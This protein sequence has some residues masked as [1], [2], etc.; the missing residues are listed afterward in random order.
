MRVLVL[1]IVS[2]LLAAPAGLAE[3][4]QAQAADTIV[5]TVVTRNTGR[6]VTGATV[7]VEGKDL[8]AA[9]NAFGR[10]E[11]PGVPSEPV[12]L[13][14]SAPGYLDLRLVNVAERADQPLIIDLDPTPNFLETVQ[15]TATKQP[16]SIG[17]VPAQTTIVDRQTIERR[18]DQ[19]L[20]QA[21][22]HV[23][24]AVITTQLGIFESVLLRGMP[25][26][27]NEFTNTLLLIDGVPQTN[28]G[29]DARVVAL[30]IN[31]AGSIE[32][33]RGPNSALYGRTAIGGSINVLTAE[34]T[35]QPE[36]TVDFTGG[37]YGSA[38]GVLSA[39]GPINQWGGYYVSV[40]N[41]R[42]GGY[43][44][45]KVDQNFTMGNT[46][47]FG[48]L[49]FVPDGRSFGS[50]SVNRVI[51]D[52]STPTNEP[53]ID[54]R[55]LHEVDPRFERFTSFNLPGPN[56]HQEE[57]RV[58]FNYNRQLT[59]WARIVET[60]GYRAVQLKFDEDGDFIGEPYSLENHT[61]TMYPFSQQADEDVYYQEAR[62][63]LTANAGMMRHAVTFGGSYERNNGM[64]ASDFIFTDDDLFGFPDIDYIN[65]VIP[66]RNDWGHFE[67]SR[68]YN[69]GITGLFGQYIVEPTPRLVITAAGRYDRL[70]MDVT[71]AGRGLVEDTFDAFSPKVGAT[72]KL[73]G[74]EGTGPALNAYGAYSQA[75]LPPRRP[76]ALVPADVPLNLQPE[77]IENWEGGLK[78]NLLDGRL[79]V[80]AS[81]FY[82]TED[83]V[84]L[85]QR[86]GA[87]FV[88][89][90]AG[91]R[92]FK[93]IET[94]AGWTPSAQVSAY[95]NASFYRNR[96]G[97]FVIES[98]GGNTELTGNRVRMSPDRIVN[99]GANVT[100]VPVI[101]LTLDVKHMGDVVG[102][103][104][105]SFLLDSYTLV[106]AA[107]S[108]QR[109]PLRLT[110]SAHN[111][112]NAEYYWNGDGESADPGAPR[113]VLVSTSVRFR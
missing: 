27:G 67:G 51:S 4:Q 90:N 81:Y 85:N 86:Q 62:L 2:G 112:F 32:I 40:A 94:G 17:D 20:A 26:I 8:G 72:V 38:K 74:T 50:I 101:D 88:P 89:T 7:A 3:A 80:E 113:Q 14:V 91:Q 44:K 11:L 60:F 55:L 64:L 69:L 95:L 57:G 37:Q 78:G 35:A 21:V 107:V 73:L 84:V 82:L 75:F 106:D 66:D 110:L 39:S 71:R 12:V 34:P 49:K 99:W 97:E 19:R 98:A 104:D 59:D 33:V 58:T 36:L 29:N 30:P 92:K 53:V 87:F 28:S 96:Y 18:N 48:K 103:E 111:L 56:Y 23:P 9:A 79:S 13:I 15:V 61:V 77:D 47:L 83:G 25:R 41:E 22:E 5:G 10:F 24:G 102:N 54:G 31:D 76:S 1:M 109:G 63:E 16:L 65:P 46:A 68:V 70:A 93:G 42:T 6:P 108:W 52:N 43:F 45:N 100:P 105:N